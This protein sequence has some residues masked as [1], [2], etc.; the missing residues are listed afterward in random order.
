MFNIIAR[1]TQYLLSAIAGTRSL[2]SELRTLDS[3]LVRVWDTAK[4][5]QQRFEPRDRRGVC[6]PVTRDN[7]VAV[8]QV[9]AVVGYLLA[10]QVCE[11]SA[12]LF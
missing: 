9:A 7:A 2:D 12:R 8:L 3:K 4:L 5:I 6:W 11:S 10:K 1:F